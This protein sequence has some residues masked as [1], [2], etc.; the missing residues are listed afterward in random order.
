MK[1]ASGGGIKAKHEL[2][3]RQTI[4]LTRREIRWLQNERLL[5]H[6]ASPWTPAQVRYVCQDGFSRGAASAEAAGYVVFR[7]LM[8][9]E[10]ENFLGF[11]NLDELPEM[12]IGR[13]L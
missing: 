7:Q 4:S 13:A 12:K 3:A 11:P 8:L 1:S 10:S 9:W 6:H 5:W 2:L